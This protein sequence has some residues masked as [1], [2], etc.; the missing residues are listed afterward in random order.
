METEGLGRF[1]LLASAIAGRLLQVEPGVSGGPAWTDGITVFVDASAGPLEQLR[2]ITVQSSLLAGGSLDAD[3]LGGLRRPVVARRYLAIEGHRA[4]AAQELLLPL[5]ARRL[6][7]HRAASRSDSPAASLAL[8]TS[9]ADVGNAPPEFGVIRPKQ[10]RATAGLEEIGVET[11]PLFPRDEMLRE[12]DD[13]EDDE[14]EPL[15]FD[16]ASPVGGGGAIGRLLKRF[17]A[18]A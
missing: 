8:A 16:I 12:L 9:R 7:D 13:G 2:S 3:V 4:L 15:V 6:I 5:A 18:D 1:A 11:R 17:L 14:H 10:M